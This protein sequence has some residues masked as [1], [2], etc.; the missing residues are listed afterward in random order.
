MVI[1]KTDGSRVSYILLN[2]IFNVSE[3]QFILPLGQKLEYPDGSKFLHA[4][5]FNKEYALIRN[6]KVEGQPLPDK[7]AIPWNNLRRIG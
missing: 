2:G 6:W 1:T 3:R 4:G 7:I 5:D